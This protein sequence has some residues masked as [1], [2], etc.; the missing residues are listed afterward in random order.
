MRQLSP[1][2]YAARRQQVM[3]A[4]GPESVLVL[5]S[6]PERRRS[7]DTFYRYR[8]SSDLLYLCGF[9]EPEAVLV[10][11]P[12]AACPFTLFVRPRDRERETWDGYRAGPEGAK[13]QYGADAAYNLDELGA[14]MP[15]IVA[16]RSTIY[17]ALG[18]SR[19]CDE[20]VLRWMRGLKGN[21]R[22]GDRA[23]AMIADPLRL[24]HR[25][26]MVKDVGELERLTVAAEISAAGHLAAMQATR[27][28]VMEYELE[29]ILTETFRGQGGTGHSYEPIVAGGMRSCVLHYN[30]NDAQLHDGDLVLIDAGAEFEGYA[31][32]ITRTWPVGTAFSGPQRDVYEA[33]LDAQLLALTLTVAGQSNIGVHDATVQRLTENMVDIGLLTTSV[34][35][36]LENESYRE[37]YMHGT[38]HYLGLDV[39][40]VGDYRDQRDA[41][42]VYKAGMVLTVE[43]GLY[44]RA[45]CDAP[46][47]FRGI[48]IRIEDDVVI[49]AIGNTVLTSAVPKSVEAIEA[50]RRDACAKN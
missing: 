4:I 45:D 39:H 38:G 35:E 15:D 36:A 3:E 20:E 34:T 28:G 30:E 2:N 11:A 6:S 47:A 16:G 41:P 5:F 24:L 19:R 7:N 31:G 32:D 49:E 8:Q 33:V 9:P 29:A 42:V 22:Q 46:E 40:D 43:P 21:R 1:M 10:L 13:T 44:V 26:R 50:I 27:P 17:H 37:Y 18:V 14:R 12:G 23:P 25:Q 48:G